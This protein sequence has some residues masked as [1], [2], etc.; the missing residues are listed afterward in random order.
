VTDAAFCNAEAQERPWLDL[1]DARTRVLAAL[2]IVAGVLAIRSPLVLFAGVPVLLAFALACGL[3]LR[4]IAA[5]MAHAEGFLLVLLLMLP[6][7]VPG[8][9]AMAIGPVDFSQPGLDRAVKILLRVNLSALAVL[10]L[11]A[12]L[13]PSRFGHALASL[14]VPHKLAH[15]LLFSARWAA[16]VKQEALRLH[17]ALRARAFRASTSA[18]TLRTLGHFTGQLLVRAMER[19]ERVDEA[20]R[21]RGFSGRFA[22][23]AEEDFGARDAV[24][25]AGVVGCLLGALLVD[26]MT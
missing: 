5:R 11:L 3:R 7:T 17:D 1:L 22:L 24:F 2:A 19:A 23:V 13:E 20:M 21:C 14:G 6:L 10:I 16:L 18:H 9:A 15:L 4:D 25:A 26:R 8:P 12:G